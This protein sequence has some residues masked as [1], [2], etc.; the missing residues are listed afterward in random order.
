MTTLSEARD[1]IRAVLQSADVEIPAYSYQ[2]DRGYPPFAIVVPGSPYIEGRVTFA[3]LLTR[4][5]I[6]LVAPFGSSEVVTEQLDSM[7]DAAFAAFL[8]AGIE[9]ESVDEPDAVSFNGSDYLATNMTVVYE[10]R[11]R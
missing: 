10:I 2:P 9:V 7:L 8:E 4:W 3:T 1:E 6:Q 5:T 11:T